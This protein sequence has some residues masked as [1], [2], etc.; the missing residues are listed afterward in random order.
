MGC[1]LYENE[2]GQKSVRQGIFEWEER[3]KKEVRWQRE[4]NNGDDYGEDHDD[5]SV[6]HD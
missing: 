4:Y 1:W 5:L 6:K 3:R 2:S